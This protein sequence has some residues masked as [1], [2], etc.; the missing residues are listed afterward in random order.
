[1]GWEYRVFYEPLAGSGLV[2]DE[3]RSVAEE[4]RTDVYLPHGARVGLKRRAGTRLE[5]KLRLKTDE[6]GFEKWEK[7]QLADE[8]DV[9]AQLAKLQRGAEKGTPPPAAEL[10]AGGRRLVVEKRRCQASVG[11]ACVVEQTELRVWLEG[12][13][14]D[15]DAS[16][17]AEAWRTVAVEGKRSHCAPVVA[18][19]LPLC[20]A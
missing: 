19:L 15:G 13:D 2:L 6:R 18:R 11:G 5:L 20:C 10:D 7:C 1:M 4:T 3:L 16:S 14:D 9:P 12:G 8:R 17:R